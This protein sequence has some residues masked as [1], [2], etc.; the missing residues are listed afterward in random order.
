MGDKVGFGYL[1]KLAGDTVTV[2][3]GGPHSDTGVLVAVK[4]DYLVLKTEDKGYV[5][6]PFKHLK[7]VVGNTKNRGKRLTVCNFRRVRSTCFS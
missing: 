7:R 2:F 1:E 6:Y 3:K 4:K 5:Y